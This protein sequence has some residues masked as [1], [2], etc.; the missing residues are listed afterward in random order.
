MR[1]T[2]AQARNMT[3]ENREGII[4][5]CK[6]YIR[7]MSKDLIQMKRD[8]KTPQDFLDIKTIEA[9]I[10]HDLETIDAL[11]EHGN[12][13][14]TLYDRSGK[15]KRDIYIDQ[16]GTVL[17]VMHNVLYFTVTGETDDI[18]AIDPDGGPF[19]SKGQ[20]IGDWKIETIDFYIQIPVTDQGDEEEGDEESLVIVHG[21]GLRPRAT[22]RRE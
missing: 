6:N 3:P 21:T 15:E 5:A 11:V 9:N 8:A 12:T 19:I 1:R 4:A 7:V 10:K 2:G 20:M 13:R 17:I 22:Q 16:D 18:K 14:F